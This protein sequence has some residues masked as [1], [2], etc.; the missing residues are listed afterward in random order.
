MKN[1]RERSNHGNGSRIRTERA[2]ACPA[3]HGSGFITEEMQMKKSIGWLILIVLLGVA[4]IGFYVW[5]QGPTFQPQPAA[6]AEAPAAPPPVTKVEPPTHYPLPESS[7]A[8]TKAL[9]P[10]NDSDAVMHS[11]LADLLG[12]AAL[13]KLFN[14][15][16][17]VRHIVVTIDNLPRRTVATRLLPTKPVAGTFLTAKTSDAL[18]IAP[19][20]A[21][22]YTPY[23]RLAEMANTKKLVAA[24]VKL[25]PLFQRAYQELGYPNGYFNDRAVAVID[26]LLA[27]P[28]VDGP[29]ALK[30]PHVLY[31]FADPALEAESAGH[32]L[33]IRMGSENAARIKVKLREIRHELTSAALSK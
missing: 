9:P 33:L 23:V 13:K 4:A 17:I 8:E 10:L 31:E 16:D 12:S 21:A 32:K 19:Q 29:V 14:P 28:E 30:Q 25:Y 2:R 22:R 7:E 20:N 6:P 11:A 1:D 15:E 27:A 5:R 18:V 26:H 24:Y 3:G